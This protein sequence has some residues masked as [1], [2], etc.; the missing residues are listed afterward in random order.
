MASMREIHLFRSQFW[1][2][3]VQDQDVKKIPVSSETSLP[4][5]QRKLPSFCVLKQWRERE[6]SLVSLFL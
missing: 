1:R 4:D 5:L 3:E 6:R 2:K